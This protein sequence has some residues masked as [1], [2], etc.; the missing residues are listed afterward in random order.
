MIVQPWNLLS[1]DD[2]DYTWNTGT[3]PSSAAGTNFGYDW[4]G[5]RKNPPSN[6]NPMQ[7]NSADQ[8]TVWPQ[9][10][11]YT[12]YA[13]GS[14]HEQKSADGSTV[15]KEYIYTPANLL[16]EVIHWDVQGD[17]SSS[18]EWDAD[19]NRVSLTSS[20]G[21]GTWEFVYDPTAGIPAV[22]EEV[23]SGSVYYIREPNGA[24][25]ARATPA[26]ESWD[27]LYYHFDALGS[28]RMLTDNAGDPTD[29]YWYDGWGNTYHIYGSTEQPYQY[30]GQWGYYTHYQDDNLGLLQL[31]VRFYDPQTGRFTQE[32][33][34]KSNRSSYAYATDRPLRLVDPDGRFA[35]PLPAMIGGCAAGGLISGFGAWWGGATTGESICNGFVGCLVGAISGFILTTFPQLTAGKQCLVGLASGVIGGAGSV[36]CRRFGSRCGPSVNPW[37]ALLDIVISTAAGCFGGLTPP[38]DDKDLLDRVVA[39][40]FGLIGYDLSRAC[41]N[42]IPVRW[43]SSRR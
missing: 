16:S 23:H 10:N 41:A 19:G 13:T 24:L 21:T 32:D 9:H 7:Y 38:G 8:L 43:G 18:M 29:Q 15:E 6:P 4:V 5:N 3:R 30:V 40:T 42:D 35:L 31:G 1:V 22:I 12:Y 2:M 17:P 33:P 37:C 11:Q 36:L 28:T 20:K 27:F 25:I 26:G 34:V 39:F 14:L